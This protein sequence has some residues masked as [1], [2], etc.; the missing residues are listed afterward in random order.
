[1]SPYNAETGRF[2]AA[3][4]PAGQHF[5]RSNFAFPA[6]GPGHRVAVGGAVAEPLL[7]DPRTL[8]ATRSLIVTLECAGNGRTGMAPLPTGEPWGAGAVG[9]AVWSGVPLADVLARAVPRD[10]AIEVL[11]EGADRG[12][13]DEGGAAIPFARSLPIAEALSRDV[14]LATEM[15]GSPL[16]LEHGAPLRLVVPRAYGMASVK[17]VAR[18]EVLARPFD[19][20]FQRARYR[21]IDAR[22]AARE[23]GPMRVKSLIVA[24]AAGATVPRGSARVWGWAWSGG[25]EVVRV[26]LAVGG[27]ERW[28]DATLEPSFGP[29]AWRRWSAEILVERPGR[30]VLRSRATDA[31]GA[32]QPARAEWNALGYANHAVATVMF[33]AR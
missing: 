3:I 28:V 5:V 25:G 8:A 17:W 22:G 2:D 13:P 31:T 21:L 6:L 11:V 10:D 23:L 29:H 32:T 14:L 18:I 4:V 9:T 30:H 20:H 33:D 12:A 1:M 15:N 27:G 24:P 19:G 26:E 7:L 16:P